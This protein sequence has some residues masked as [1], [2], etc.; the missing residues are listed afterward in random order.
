MSEL[1]KF[2]VFSFQNTILKLFFT[3]HP[4]SI[5]RLPPSPEDFLLVVVVAPASAMFPVSISH[6]INTEKQ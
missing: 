3:V 4:I 2:V 5:K 6:T 1:H